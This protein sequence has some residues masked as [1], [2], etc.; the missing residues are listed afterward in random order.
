MLVALGCFAGTTLSFATINSDDETGNPEEATVVVEKENETENLIRGL[1]IPF[2]MCY[3]SGEL[4]VEFYDEI[5]DLS[6]SVI[7]TVT[8]EMWS[9]VVTSSA[10]FGTMSLETTNPSG[11]Y[12]LMI[13]DGLGHS[14]IG[15]FSLR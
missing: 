8:G 15:Y 2:E 6:V 4:L 7:N 12:Q 14:Y 13:E 11:D 9:D 10:G 1:V 5:G 3:R